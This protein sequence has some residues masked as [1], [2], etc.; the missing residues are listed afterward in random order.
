MLHRSFHSVGDRQIR[1][2]LCGWAGH[3]SFCFGH[4]HQIRQA[5]RLR[6][7]SRLGHGR[8]H[9]LSL[10]F[11]H[12]G[13]QTL[14]S[15]RRRRPE[16]ATT[17]AS[18]TLVRFFFRL[19]GHG[20]EPGYLVRHQH[21]S[22]HFL[23]VMHANHMC[24]VQNSRCHR[25][26]RGEND[27]PAVARVDQEALARG[28]R[29]HRII[30]FRETRQLG[31]DFRILLF[32][33]SETQAGIHYDTVLFHAGPPRPAGGGIQVFHHTPG[34]IRQRRQTAPGLRSATHVVQNQ[35][36]IP[37]CG[38]FRQPGVERQPTRVVQNLDAILQRPLRDFRLVRIQ[39]KRYAHVSAQPPEHWHQP[40][41][42]LIRRDALRF[43]TGR[44]RANVDDVDALLFHLHGARVSTVRVK[45][46]PP[47]GE[48]VGRDVQHAHYKR[49]FTQ[50]QLRGP[51]LPVIDLSVHCELPVSHAELE[52]IEN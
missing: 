11:T 40:L 24:P 15:T 18:G 3:Y 45:E 12:V 47:I 35:P 25:G 34:H 22:A 4:L 28:R 37:V 49:P 51:Q 50:L 10:L 14:R 48:R 33:L 13:R 43:G 42:F 27:L 2:A 36:G 5:T 31:Q 9:R 44:F 32:A 38:H 1:G 26:S 6:S 7:N 41:P 8:P 39:R 17:G 23:Y 30:Q 29:Q 19:D 46:A 20:P 21:H 16:R 52:R